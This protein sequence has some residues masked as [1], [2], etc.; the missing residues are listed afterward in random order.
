MAIKMIQHPSLNPN[1]FRKRSH[2]HVERI[3]DKASQLAALLALIATEGFDQFS[4]MKDDIQQNFLWACFDLACDI[5]EL[6][7]KGA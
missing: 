5:E 1:P 6:A 4:R 2:V 7:A 3:H